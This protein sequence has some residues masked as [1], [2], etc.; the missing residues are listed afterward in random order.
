V[1]RMITNPCREM[2]EERAIYRII[3][4]ETNSYVGVYSRAYHDEM[5]F[6]SEEQARAAN[7]HGTFQDRGKYDVVKLKKFYWK[8]DV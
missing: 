8:E 2:I 5:D 4:K 6:D 7:C 3:N 1:D